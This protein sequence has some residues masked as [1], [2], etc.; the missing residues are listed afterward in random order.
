MFVFDNESL[1]YV[2]IGLYGCLNALLLKMM[3]CRA[4]FVCRYVQTQK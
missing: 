3:D 1:C 2:K 4:F